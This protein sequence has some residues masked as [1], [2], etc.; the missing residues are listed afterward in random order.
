M[1]WRCLGFSGFWSGN[2]SG[3]ELLFLFEKQ[4]WWKP[5]RKPNAP[6]SCMI[7]PL[8]AALNVKINARAPDGATALFIAA[9]HG[10]TE[11]MRN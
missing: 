2:D 10:H 5:W 1:P 6:A 3:A 11:V 4:H 9:F 7:K 8:L